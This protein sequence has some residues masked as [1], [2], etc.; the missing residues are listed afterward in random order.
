MKAP[1][2]R[3]DWGNILPEVKNQ[4]VGE[5]WNSNSWENLSELQVLSIEPT[6]LAIGNII[7]HISIIYLS[8]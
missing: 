7:K 5:E 1:P 8:R 6:L 2:I 4:V 3:D